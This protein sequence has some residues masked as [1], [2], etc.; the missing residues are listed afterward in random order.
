MNTL[1][2]ER[3]WIGPYPMQRVIHLLLVEDNSAHAKLA[4]LAIESGTVP[5]TVDWVTD[6]EQAFAYLRRDPPYEKRPDVDL[7]L[8]DLRSPRMDGI[9][10]LRRIKADLDL[11]SIPVIIL[12]SSLSRAEVEEA[13][14]HHANSYLVKPLNFDEFQRMIR[15]LLVYWG[16]WNQPR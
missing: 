4:T 11:R 12:S 15:D 3:I 13:Y 7:I 9:E 2:A 10:A 5:A 1:Q 8:L 6:G 16:V 14:R